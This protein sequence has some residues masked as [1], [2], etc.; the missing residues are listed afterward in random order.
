[1]IVSQILVPERVLCEGDAASKKRVLELIAERLASA[2][3]GLDPRVVFDAL[4]ARER[5]GST[6]LGHGV[7]LPHARLAGIASA[8]G[9]LVHLHAGVDFDAPDGHPVDLV[10]GLLVPDECT[11][12][13]LQILATLA[14]RFASARLREALRAAESADEA[15]AILSAVSADA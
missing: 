14:E 5:L 4:V 13:H 6:A 7:A 12:E 3:D 2:G 15:C 1:M 8:A 10:F 9:A 11:E